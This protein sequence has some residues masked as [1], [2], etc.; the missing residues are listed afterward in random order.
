VDVNVNHKR[1]NFADDYN[2]NNNKSRVPTQHVNANGTV[3]Q[4]KAAILNKEEVTP[5]EYLPKIKN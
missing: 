5:E 2:N 1:V 4:L 3:D